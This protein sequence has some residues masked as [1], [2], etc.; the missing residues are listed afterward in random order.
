[1]NRVALA[2]GRSRSATSPTLDRVIRFQDPPV[3]RSHGADVSVRIETVA[4]DGDD[5]ADH[6]LRA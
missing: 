2:A 6:A 3:R 1:M 4:V 5:I